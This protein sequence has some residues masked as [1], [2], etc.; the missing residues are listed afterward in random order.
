M[1]LADDHGAIRD[2]VSELA[3]IFK[4]DGSDA[5]TMVGTGAV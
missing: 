2:A 4:C 5:D 1:Q 3:A